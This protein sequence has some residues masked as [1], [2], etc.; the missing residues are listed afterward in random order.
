MQPRSEFHPDT[1]AE[2]ARAVSVAL[3]RLVRGDEIED[4]L[5]QLPRGYQEVLLKIYE[6]AR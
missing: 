4:L 2:H 3:A 6:T 5:A 1:A